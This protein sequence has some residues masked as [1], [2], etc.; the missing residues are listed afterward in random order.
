MRYLTV[1]E[2]LWLHKLI[3]ANHGGRPGVQ[4][5]DRLETAAAQPQR[6]YGGTDFYPT[7]A[8]QIGE[9]AYSIVM[10]DSV[11]DGNKRVGH[12]AMEAFLMLNGYD[13]DSA[14]GEQ[15]SLVVDLASGRVAREQLSEWVKSHMR[16][17]LT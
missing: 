3:I 9:L 1:A 2:L 12:A 4:D 13:M 11:V 8:E 7:I 10:G 5:L 15:E 17:L 14:G 16:P 6:T